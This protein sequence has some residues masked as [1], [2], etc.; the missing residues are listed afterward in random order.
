MGQWLSVSACSGS[1]YI[2]IGSLG[3]VV[4]QECD[5][6][7]HLSAT[8]TNNTVQFVG[9]TANNVG[10]N[11]TGSMLTCSCSAAEL[12]LAEWLGPLGS[13]VSNGSFDPTAGI[14]YKLVDHPGTAVQLH[15]TNN[16]FSCS[17]AGNYTCVIG[18]NRREVLVLPIGKQI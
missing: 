1:H 12:S 16:T 13:P 2:A 10:G 6:S 3:Q 8:N 18:E 4:P 17:E 15:T 11:A 14:N 5:L 9:L 7:F